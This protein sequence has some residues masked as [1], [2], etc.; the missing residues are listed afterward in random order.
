V[1]GHGKPD[2]DKEIL[3]CRVYDTV[4]IPITSPSRLRSGPPELPGLTAASIWDQ[5]FDHLFAGGGLEGT[6][7][8]EDDPALMEL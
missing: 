2:A 6:V 8:P 3:V 7:E 4:T 5:T 1:I